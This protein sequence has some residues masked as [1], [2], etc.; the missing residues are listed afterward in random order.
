MRLGFE[1]RALAYRSAVPGCARSGDRSTSRSP[2]A[3]RAHHA[4]R[5]VGTLQH[6]GELCALGALKCAREKVTF[7]D[8]RLLP[9]LTNNGRSRV[10]EQRVGGHSAPQG[11]R[12][13]PLCRRWR[14]RSPCHRRGAG[15]GP[16]GFPATA[17]RTM[18]DRT[19][20]LP[21][22]EPPKDRLRG[23][24]GA[25]GFQSRLS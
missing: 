11:M 15:H 13:A 14:R 12:D 19:P 17:Q 23:S 20:R 21:G 18:A 22:A 8:L 7:R 16:A 3:A 5:S 9:N 25:L 24:I 10:S 6:K 2:G 1:V 4:E